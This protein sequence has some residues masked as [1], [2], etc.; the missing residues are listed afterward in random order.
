[1]GTCYNSIVGVGLGRHGM[2]D[3]FAI[4]TD[5]IGRRE[6][7]TRSNGWEPARVIKWARRRILNDA[8]H[9]TLIAIDDDARVLRYSIDDGPGPVAR[10]AVRNYIG[11][12]R[13]APV[14]S[15]DTAFVEW[16]SSYDSPDDAAVG[17]LCNPIYRAL[18][19]TLRDHFGRRLIRAFG[20]FC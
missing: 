19:T 13:V 10:D 2:E 12:L 6:S 8:F 16:E 17:E 11:R 7:F 20:A 9:E 5:S 14:T 15:D 4:F 18:L 3:L 1:M